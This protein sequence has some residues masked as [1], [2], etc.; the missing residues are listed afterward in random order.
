MGG[1]AIHD[2]G[3]A[4]RANREIHMTE[5][6]PYA[7]PPVPGAPVSVKPGGTLGIV[8][9]VLAILFSI[10]GAIIGLVARSQSKKAGFTNGPATAAIIVGFILFV[11]QIIIGVL[12]AVA[13]AAGVN[14]LQKECNSLG[15][16]Q[17]VVNGVTYTCP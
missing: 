5:P 17:H 6:T 2:C 9:L 1:G 7:A 4:I 13:I 14:A 16:G 10:V 15:S 8:A 11:L 3:D 12:I